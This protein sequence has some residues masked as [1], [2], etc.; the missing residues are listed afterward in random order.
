MHLAGEPTS[1][2]ELLAPGGCLAS[3][4]LFGADQHPAAVSIVA[5]ASR[6]TL[7]RLAADVAA[8]RVT[9]PVTRRYPLEDAPRAL[10]DFTLGTIGKYAVDIQG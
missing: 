4:L 6:A 1:L 7:D 2:V 3:T 9:V 5:D 10:A 8:G